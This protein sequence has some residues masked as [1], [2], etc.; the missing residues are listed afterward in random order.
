MV[1]WCIQVEVRLLWLHRGLSR[2]PALTID[3][4]LLSQKKGYKTNRRCSWNMLIALFHIFHLLII[5]FL[6]QSPPFSSE[7]F[8]FPLGAPESNVLVSWA[9]Y[10]AF[11][12]RSNSYFGGKIKMYE[13]QFSSLGETSVPPVRTFLWYYCPI[14]LKSS[15][16]ISTAQIISDEPQ[17]VILPAL[18]RL[19]RL[20]GIW[21][22]LFT[23][24]PN[25]ASH[26]P[27]FLFCSLEWSLTTS[28]PP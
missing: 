3:V 24:I 20:Q 16:M 10:H 2:K 5:I 22:Q 7:L 15:H 23:F 17:R 11:A 13:A 28:Q 6:G 12:I 18:S 9:H 26:S 25:C 4:F 14:T 27:Y 21:T 19:A 8:C 1:S